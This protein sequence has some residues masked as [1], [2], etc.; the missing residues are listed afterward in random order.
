MIEAGQRR[1]LRIL[2]TLLGDLTAVALAYVAAFYLRAMIPLARSYMPFGRFFQVKHYW[3]LLFVSQAAV[4]YFF[5]LYDRIHQD[6]K[7][8]ALLQI[9]VALF[10]QFLLVVAFYFFAGEFLFP[11][12]I[13]VGFYILNNVLILAWRGMLIDVYAPKSQKRVILFGLGKTAREFIRN[14]EEN[15]YFG[16]KIVGLV[17]ENPSNE[18]QNGPVPPATQFE[19]YPILG[20]RDDLV[21]VVERHKVDA[22]VM[23][24]ESSWQDQLIDAI[25]R[26]EQTNANIFVVPSIFE[27]LISKMQHLQIHDIPLVEVVRNPTAGARF[28]TK[29]MLDIFFSALLLLLLLPVFA[30]V[31]ATIR[32]SS[33]GPVVYRQKRVG[34]DGAL[35]VVYKFRT[36]VLDAEAKTG[37]VLASENDA[38]VTPL[39]KWLRQLRLDELPQLVN[40]LEG[41][42]S[43]VGPRPERPEFV[44]KFS[45][46]IPGYRER[47]K[48]K[49]GITGLAQV[50]G[51]YHTSPEMKLRYDLAYIHN[52]N[53]LLDLMIVLETIKIVLTR[54]GV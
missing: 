41:N 27:M 31:A 15:P 54:K 3:L 52:H 2:V 33:P 5:G 19:G 21:Q 46:T 50:H 26:S 45:E 29:R 16:L 47:F 34:K 17:Q 48:M 36:M 22:I 53:L 32:I 10:I 23:I 18:S 12:S 28:Y 49:P 43:F 51:E 37:A 30:I 42:M 40:I 35:F 14:L 6:Q 24:P 38:R 8:Q 13:F 25:G 20:T 11:R 39:G 9:P 44:E 1:K 4:L 7:R